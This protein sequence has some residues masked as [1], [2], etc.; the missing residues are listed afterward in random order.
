MTATCERRF[1]DSAFVS[2]LKIMS[3]ACGKAVSGPCAPL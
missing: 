3:R 2:L 1:F